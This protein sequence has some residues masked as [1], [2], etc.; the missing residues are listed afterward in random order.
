ML[1]R[2]FPCFVA[3]WLS[4]L[5]IID[6]FGAHAGPVTTSLQPDRYRR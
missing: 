6:E 1:I 3:T 5:T 2:I 4:R